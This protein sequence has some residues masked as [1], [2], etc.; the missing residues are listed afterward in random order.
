MYHFA[1]CGKLKYVPHTIDTYSGFQWTTAI[2]SKKAD[3]VVP[4]LL[5]VITILEIPLQIK[6][7]NVLAYISNKMQQ[8]FKHYSIKHVTDI[9]YHPTGQAIVEKSNCTL[10]EM[11]IRQKG[12][13]RSPREG[14]NNALL[15]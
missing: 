11:L 2:R 3:S 15:T 12:H 6:T 5:E 8:F 9:P 13:M 10:K 14:L 1:D 7:D 4:H